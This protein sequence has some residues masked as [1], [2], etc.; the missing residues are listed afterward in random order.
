MWEPSNTLLGTHTESETF[1]HEVY[2]Y[3]VEDGPIDPETGLPTPGEE[4]YYA[5]RIT[6]VEDNPNTISFI[7]GNPATV[8]GHYGAV[9]NDQ[10]TVRG[11]NNNFTTLHTLTDGN[12]FEVV[13]LTSLHEV[14]SYKADTTR[15]RTFHYLAEALD[16][17]TVIASENYTIVCQDL[18]WTPGKNALQGLVSYASSK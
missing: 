10:L 8:G 11:Y 17:E 13:D 14:I 15:T 2:Y 16:G 3:T 18:N 1:S 5:V 4:T 9:F 7:T 6:S 12:V